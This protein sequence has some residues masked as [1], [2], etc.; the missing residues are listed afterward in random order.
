MAGAPVIRS[1]RDGDLSILSTVYRLC[2]PPSD[3]SGTRLS[4]NE[5]RN[6]NGILM[7]NTQ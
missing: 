1:N 3:G 2:G 6:E 4:R 5:P 7:I